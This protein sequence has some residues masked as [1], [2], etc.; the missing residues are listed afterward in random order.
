LFANTRVAS[1][2]PPAERYEPRTVG[3]PADVRGLVK[4]MGFLGP[5]RKRQP[6]VEGGGASCAD[7]VNG[8]DDG[9][10]DTQLPPVLQVQA[11]PESELAAAPEPEPVPEPPTGYAS[12]STMEQSIKKRKT[13]NDTAPVAPPQL[14]SPPPPLPPPGLPEEARPQPA[15]QQPMPEAQ[16][17]RRKMGRPKGSG[18]R[19][20]MQRRQ[21]EAAA[22]R[23]AAVQTTSSIAPT[24][25]SPP[26]AAAAVEPEPEG[27][28]TR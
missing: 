27:R 19:Q 10:G 1:F 16:A 13:V 25:S 7:V 4:L 21:E 20:R 3:L 24:V 6:G 2:E 22:A 5:R 26:A 14:L 11:E 12:S 28:L 9:D 17:P 8:V 18:W 23:A 15:Q